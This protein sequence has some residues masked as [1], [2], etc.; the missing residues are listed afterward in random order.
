MLRQMQNGV[1][2]VA[3]LGS[4]ILNGQSRREPPRQL[5][6]VA[7]QPAPGR[8]GSCPGCAL[9]Q[10]SF[11]G[12]DLTNVNFSGAD[13]LGSDFTGAVLS[14]ADFS[15]AD[16]TGGIWNQLR[17]QQQGFSEIAAWSPFRFNLRTG[18]EARQVDTLM[19][20]GDFFNVFNTPGNS[21]TAGSDGIAPTWTNAN[22][23]RVMQLSARL[24]W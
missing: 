20:S 22:G 13:L 3:F 9:R 17:E 7:G 21:P 4:G 12:L 6:L 19:V 11:A 1:V 18:G 14:G 2:L 10:T 16:L 8:V 23:A 5:R 24:S 15:N